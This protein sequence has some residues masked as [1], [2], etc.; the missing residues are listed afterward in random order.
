M[1]TST[2]KTIR[3][4]GRA[5]KRKVT[6]CVTKLVS[7]PVK[8]HTQFARATLTRHGILYA[9]GALRHNRLKLRARRPTDPAVYTLT[10]HYRMGSHDITSRQRLKLREAGWPPT[11]R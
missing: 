6:K 9:V 1:C 8:F 5:R 2:T 4:H 11:L 10:L 7:S 3:Q